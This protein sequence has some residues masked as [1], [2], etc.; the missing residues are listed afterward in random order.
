MQ[1]NATYWFS[2]FRI[3]LQMKH[4]NLKVKEQNGSD[5]NNITRQN[6]TGW[7]DLLYLILVVSYT[8]VSQ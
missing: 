5:T 6:S 8:A 1:I 2:L 3:N 4:R 7:A